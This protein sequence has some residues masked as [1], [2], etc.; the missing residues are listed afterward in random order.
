MAVSSP[1]LGLI[2]QNYC[3][4]TQYVK[5][6]FELIVKGQTSPTTFSAIGSSHVQKEDVGLCISLEYSQ[7]DLCNA[8]NLICFRE[9]AKQEKCFH[10]DVRSLN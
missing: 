2:P 10:H 9:R 5:E 4:A 7:L 8:F 3:S 1:A 6:K